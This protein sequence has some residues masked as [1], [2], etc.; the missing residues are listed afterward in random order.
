MD[1]MGDAIG[2]NTAGDRTRVELFVPFALLSRVIDD[3][4]TVGDQPANRDCRVLVD[5]VGA[6]KRAW[7][8][9]LRYYGLLNREDYAVFASN[10]HASAGVVH[11]FGG[12]FDLKYAAVGRKGG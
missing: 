9:H 8:E 6:T 12:I 11:G 3:D 2:E 5:D 7:Y 10:T 4:A 1:E